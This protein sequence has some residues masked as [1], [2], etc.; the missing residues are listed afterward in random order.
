MN[1]QTKKSRFRLINKSMAARGE[2]VGGWAKWVK[3][4]GRYRSPVMR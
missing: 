2:E 1:K 4:S 3:D